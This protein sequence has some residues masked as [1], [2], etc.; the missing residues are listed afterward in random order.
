MHARG[1]PTVTGCGCE[2]A[3]APQLNHPTTPEAPFDAG[4]A[5]GSFVAFFAAQTNEVTPEKNLPK[6]KPGRIPQGVFTYTL[7][8]VLAEYP[9]ATYL[10]HDPKRQRKLLLHRREIR[11]FAEVASQKGLSIV[12]LEVHLVRGNVKVTIA[13]GKGLKRHDK[14]EKLKEHDADR[15]MRQAIRRQPE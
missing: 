3:G 1:C 12:P 4:A 7:F 5:P 10:N 8:Q 2:G 11:K 15:E 13:I 9:Q 14:R 6:G